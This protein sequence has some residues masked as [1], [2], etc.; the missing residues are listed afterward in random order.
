MAL[1]AVTFQISRSTLCKK[2][3]A[4]PSPR[5]MEPNRYARIMAIY[6]ASTNAMGGLTLNRAMHC[7]AR[8][9]DGVSLL[10]MSRGRLAASPLS[11][12]QRFAGKRASIEIPKGRKIFRHCIQRWTPRGSGICVDRR[13]Q[14]VF[15]P[16]FQHIFVRGKT[17]KDGKDGK[18]L[19]LP[20]DRFLH[21]NKRGEVTSY[22]SYL[23][24]PSS[25]SFSSISLPISAESSRS[26]ERSP[27]I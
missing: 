10:P 18:D 6:R 24:H 22:G 9:A 8:T 21:R 16:R 4:R 23:I 2:F 14:F 7:A 5:K 1:G 12:V 26:I 19:L 27:N 17:G 25:W 20:T 13:V 11:V 15:H 3:T